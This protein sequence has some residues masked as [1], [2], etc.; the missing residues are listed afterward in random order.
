MQMNQDNE[1]ELLFYSEDG[2]LYGRETSH[3]LVDK[4]A[5]S[6]DFAVLLLL[7]L[8]SFLSISI[9]DPLHRLLF[10]FV[11]GT[12]RVLRENIE[13]ARLIETI[14]H[15]SLLVIQLRYRYHITAAKLLASFLR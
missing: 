6:V 3:S 9:T 13:S 15:T 7:N 8:A 12:T 2:Q 10:C 11:S 5:R 14:S 1:K 4:P